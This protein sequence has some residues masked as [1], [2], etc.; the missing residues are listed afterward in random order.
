MSCELRKH[1]VTVVALTPGFL[2]SEA[3]LDYL[4][5]TEENW[6]DGIEKDPSFANSETPYYIG[7]AVAALASDPNVMDKTGRDNTII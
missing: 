2:R 7:R 5:V 3:V 6:R 1:N 4:G